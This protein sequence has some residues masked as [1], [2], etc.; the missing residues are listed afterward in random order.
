MAR[1]MGRIFGFGCFAFIVVS[2]G[3][4]MLINRSYRSC[5]AEVD[6]R[7]PAPDSSYEGIVYHY[8]CGFGRT[9][10]TNVSIEKPGDEPGYPANLLAIMD[11]SGMGFLTGGKRPAVEL[12][13]ETADELT[14]RY[15]AGTRAMVQMPAAWGVRARYVEQ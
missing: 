9:A 1:D 2:F 5:A 12:V 11:T 13:W 6:A 15:Q 7:V 10:L 14:V 3:I 4:T 8:E